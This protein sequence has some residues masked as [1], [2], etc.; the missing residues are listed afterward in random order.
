MIDVTYILSVNYSGSHLLSQ[1]LGAHSRC[2]SIGELRNYAKFTRTDNERTTTSDFAQNPIFAGLDI[3]PQSDWYRLIFARVTAEH[4]SITMLVDNSKKPEWAARFTRNQR[5]RPHYVHLIRDPR[6]LLRRWRNDYDTHRKLRR[7]RRRL[8][9]HS[10]L[11]LGVALF[12]SDDEVLLH[13]WLRA[14]QLITR[15]MRA[16]GHP[17][18][19]LTYHDLASRPADELAPLMAGLG[20]VFEDRQLNFGGGRSFGTHKTEYATLSERSEIHMDLR[21]KNDVPFE[22]QRAVVRNQA[23]LRYL[24]EIGIAFCDDGLTRQA[25]IIDKQLEGAS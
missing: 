18:Q 9:F 6:A 21:W 8:T 20:L 13:K 24:D 12:G 23:V 25:D 11:K 16:S 22:I 7:Q 5:I 19:V 3:V 14:N 10:P 2:A 4:P 17:L 1:L 15:F